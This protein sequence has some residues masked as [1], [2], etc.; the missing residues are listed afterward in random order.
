M[1]NIIL[2][3]GVSAFLFVAGC[4]NTADGVQ[5]DTERNS[6]N[7]AAE[8]Q[9]MSKEAGE[10]GKD[11]SSAASLTPKITL[12]F[13]ADKDLNDPKNSLNVD[14]TDEKVVIKGHVTSERLK[15]RAQEVAEKVLKE[16]NAHQWLENKLTVQP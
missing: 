6:E 4:Q 3:A 9:R 10:M 15:M 8:A 2:I 11:L 7:A 5:K 1:K 14:S 16:N 13:T 12:A